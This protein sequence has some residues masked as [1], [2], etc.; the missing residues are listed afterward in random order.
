MATTEVI[1]RNKSDWRVFVQA[2]DQEPFYLPKGYEAVCNVKPG[3][4]VDIAYCDMKG[5]VWS[6]TY[7]HLCVPYKC[8]HASVTWEVED[9]TGQTTWF[10][11]AFRLRFVVG[12]RVVTK[13]T[14]RN[15]YPD[16]LREANAHHA[17]FP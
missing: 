13:D 3:K 7:Q 9:T 4:W 5:A 15:D 2:K 17:V 14:F 11:P 12:V 8:K 10:W 6:T 16:P 1:V